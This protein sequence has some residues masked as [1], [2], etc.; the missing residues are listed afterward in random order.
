V[1]HIELRRWADVGVVAP[2]SAN[3]LAKSESYLAAR[4]ALGTDAVA[5][6][7]MDW[8]TLKKT[9]K[10]EKS[11][12]KRLEPIQAFFFNEL[13]AAFTQA[14]WVAAGLYVKDDVL[15]LKIMTDSPAPSAKSFAGGTSDSDGALPNLT[16]P[17]MLASLSF[18]RDLHGFYTAKDEL[19]PER[20]SGLVF[21]ENMMGIYFSG[22][23][24]TEG[25]LAEAKPDMRVVVA[26]QEYDAAYARPA[27]EVPAFA[28]ILRL[29]HP[30]DFGDVMEEAWQKAIG[31]ASFTR[32]QKA[33]PGFIIDHVP[34]PD[35]RISVASFR[36]PK[37]KV[38]ADIRYNFRPALARYGEYIIISST[39]GLAKQLVEAVKKEA[40][41]PVKPVAKTHS[42]MEISGAQV[43]EALLKNREQL[44]LKNM[45]DKG[46]KREKAEEEMDGLMMLMSS[47]DRAQLSM[48]VE[49]GHPQTTLELKLKF[50]D[51]EH[52]KVA[53]GPPA[54]K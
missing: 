7:Y 34:T 3:S 44:V 10:V 12:E 46:H 54:A 52:I 47:I 25:V 38:G 39:D 4:K 16:V 20:T 14:N 35:G 32:G 26:D 31:M 29:K 13:R 9:P 8:A 48:G 11:F 36:A 27:V 42:L 40:A 41:K 37:E 33:L 1:L 53:N 18:Y 17:G 19:F 50:P 43:L 6:M 45:V 21:F 2:A 28:A 23:D 49:D 22:M 51:V 24:L 5:F 30:Q 15:S